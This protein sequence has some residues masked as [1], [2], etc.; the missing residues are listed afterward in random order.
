MITR[1]ELL[2]DDDLSD[3]AVCAAIID[4]ETMLAELAAEAG[5]CPARAMMVAELRAALR[6]LHVGG[7]A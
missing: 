5:D 1:D 4:P 6:G 3:A 2:T 7:E